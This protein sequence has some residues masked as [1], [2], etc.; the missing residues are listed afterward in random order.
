M[1]SGPPPPPMGGRGY[2]AFGT[3]AYNAHGGM[4]MGMGMNMGSKH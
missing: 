4:G 1:N 2:G 3:S